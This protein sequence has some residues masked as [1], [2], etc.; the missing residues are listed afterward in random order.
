MSIIEWKFQGRRAACSACTEAYSEDQRHVSVLAIAGE[1]LTREDVCLACWEKRAPAEDLFFWFTRHRVDRRR[2]HLDL[3]TLEQLFVQLDGR[4]ERKVRELR[5]VLCLLLMRKRRLK[6]VRVERGGDGES[7]V[8]KR[9]RRT[10]VH[11]VFV[12]DFSPERLGELRHE[13]IEIFEG[14]EPG[15]WGASAAAVPAALEVS[16]GDEPEPRAPGS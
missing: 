10:D 3:E 16:S 8:V 13:L 11:E 7:L 1:E 9:P 12:F 15:Q 4:H 5:Y 2:M 14:S 6:L